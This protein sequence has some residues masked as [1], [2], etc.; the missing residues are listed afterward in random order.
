MEANSNSIGNAVALKHEVLEKIEEILSKG[1]ENIP[2]TFN[3]ATKASFEKKLK[4][5]SI[6]YKIMRPL[7]VAMGMLFTLMC[8]S[9]ILNMD[10]FFSYFEWQNGALFFLLT[11][12]LTVNAFNLKQQMER[13]KLLLYLIEMVER[14]EKIK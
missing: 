6:R 1:K 8:L 12:S 14:I 2:V 4:R 11:L 7:T 5:A 9:Q 10:F 3:G 13:Y